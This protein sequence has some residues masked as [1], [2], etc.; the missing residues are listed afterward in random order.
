LYLV[1]A[2]LRPVNKQKRSIEDTSPGKVIAIKRDDDCLGH[3]LE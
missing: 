1:W 3:G 2:W